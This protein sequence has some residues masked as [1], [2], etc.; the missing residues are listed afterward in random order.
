MIYYTSNVTSN[1]KQWGRTKVWTKIFG[2]IQIFAWF[3]HTALPAL[4]FTWPYPGMAKARENSNSA[5]NFGPHFCST[6]SV[7]LWHDFK[8]KFFKPSCQWT[9][10]R[11]PELSKPFWD[12]GPPWRSSKTWVSIYLEHTYSCIRINYN[13]ILYSKQKWKIHLR[14]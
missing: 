4:T 3:C 14:K 10:P 13:H 7:S 1:G 6:S 5:K 2:R 9:S 12:P 8:K 11:F